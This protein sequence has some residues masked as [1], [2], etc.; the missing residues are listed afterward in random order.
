MRRAIGDAGADR[1]AV[2]AGRAGPEQAVVAADDRDLRAGDR[3]AVIEARDEDQ[4]V[5]RAVLDGDAEVR[6]LDDRGARR[7]LADR[8]AFGIGA[9][10]STAAQTSPVPRGPSALADVEPVRLDPIGRHAELAIDRPARRASRLK[11]GVQRCA[12]SASASSR[13]ISGAAH[14]FTP[15]GCARRTAARPPLDLP[16]AVAVAEAGERRAGASS[17]RCRPRCSRASGRRRTEPGVERD[18]VGASPA[19]APAKPAS[20][21]VRCSLSVAARD[22]ACASAS[23]PAWRRRLPAAR[24]DIAS[25]GRALRSRRPSRRV[26]SSIGLPVVGI[27]LG[28]AVEARRRRTRGS[29]SIVNSCGVPGVAAPA[30]DGSRS[31]ASVSLTQLSGG[32]RV[33][34]SSAT[35]SAT[36]GSASCP[37]R[38]SAQRDRRGRRG[39]GPRRRDLGVEAARA[40]SDRSSQARCWRPPRTTAR[41]TR[42]ARTAL[43]CAR[44]VRRVAPAG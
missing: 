8:R 5:L 41:A 43:R 29:T 40:P 33:T 17:R 23:P 35:R 30:G 10:F 24:R 9:P 3:R 7:L 14:C 2:R 21:S 13:A 44:D 32:T 16:D 36:A 6:D 39:G 27:A 42:A 20:S 4:R 1:D 25:R 15:K 28:R 12:S 34:V 37:S 26:R 18:D 22:L 31:S 11:S 38:S 19:A